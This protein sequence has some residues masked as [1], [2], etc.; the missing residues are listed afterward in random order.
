MGV[1]RDADA[2]HRAD[3]AEPAERFVLEFSAHSGRLASLRRDFEDWLVSLDTHE[4]DVYDLVVAVNEAASNAVEHAYPPGGAGQIRV[5]AVVTP[6]GSVVAVVS[7]NGRWRVPPAAL[8]SRGRGLLLMRENVDEVLIDRGEDGTTVSLRLTPRSKRSVVA[9]PARHGP[10][11]YEVL[12][13]NREGWVQVT[14]RGNVPAPAETTLRRSL[15]T[16][17]RGGSVP[18]VVDLCPL[19][20]E[21]D[22]VATTLTA[23]AEAAA[24]AGNKVVVLAAPDSPAW[25]ALTTAGVQHVVDIVAHH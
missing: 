20:A 10:R 15:L 6:D 16:A 8:S 11:G 7:D 13:E 25:D 24:A 1:T 19:G 5:E 22:G 9:F 12:V 3:G 2:E 23:V 18:I 14:L 4:D 17:A 21:I